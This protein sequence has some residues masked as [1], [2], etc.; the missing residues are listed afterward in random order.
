MTT[1]ATAF[2][3]SDQGEKNYS[4]TFAMN[5][6]NDFSTVD[7]DQQVGS[8]FENYSSSYLSFNKPTAFENNTSS[9]STTAAIPNNPS[10]SPSLL[11]SERVSS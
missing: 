9:S 3:S 2:S 7:L 1:F 4:D 11:S 8:T 6:T 10:H 5:P